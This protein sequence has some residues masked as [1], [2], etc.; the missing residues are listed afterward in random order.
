MAVEIEYKYLVKLD[1]WNEVSPAKSVRII[2]GY[3]ST[4]PSKSIRVRMLD[5]KGFITIKGMAER[6]KR[7][8]YEYE[9]PGQDAKELLDSFCTKL[10]SKTRYYVQHENH[11]WEVDVFDGLNSGLVVAEIELQSEDEAYSKPEW[12]GEDVTH[13]FRY[14]NSNLSLNPYSTW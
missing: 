12:L 9:I 6:A 10:V 14:S 11:T 5:Q 7:L 1:L 3:I 4:E 2:Q 13:D 8:E